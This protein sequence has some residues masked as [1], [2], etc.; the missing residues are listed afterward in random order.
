MSDTG[1]LWDSADETAR[2][3]KLGEYFALWGMAPDGEPF[4]THSSWLAPARLNGAAVMLKVPCHPEERNAM[5]ALAWYGGRGAARVLRRDD[6]AV[7]ME[8]LADDRPL[9]A[10]AEGGQDDEATRILCEATTALHERR[11]ESFP[12]SA[13]TLKRWFRSLPMMAAREAS[14]QGLM[15]AGWREAERLLN[16]PCD[17]V[18]LHGDIHHD[19]V[20]HD[21]ARGWAA[22]DPKGVVG[23]SGYDFAN[24]LCNP[25]GDLP[26]KPGRMGRQARVVAEATGRPLESVLAWGVAYI[27]LSTAWHIE[28]GTLE[29]ENALDYCR[30]AQGE[31]AAVRA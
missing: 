1:V 30:V 5:A 9:R 17:P 16:E 7:V 29:T 28:S 21:P 24:M 11:A 3:A 26:L 22:I 8:R 15:Q 31:L 20:L 14:Y 4:A 19:N 18:L 23:N 10:M 2:T 27:A 12:A 25:L 13:P 6:F